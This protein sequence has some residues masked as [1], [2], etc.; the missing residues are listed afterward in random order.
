MAACQI[1]PLLRLLFFV[2]GTAQV[3]MCVL[4]AGWL[5][6]FCLKGA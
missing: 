1:V 2:F 4:A 3:R 5:I 6:S